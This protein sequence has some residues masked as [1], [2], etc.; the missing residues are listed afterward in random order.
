VIA[1]YCVPL[2]EVGG[3]AIAMKGR[4]E[5]TELE[6]GGRA[7]RELGAKIARVEPV[8]MIPEVGEKVRK[9][10]ILEKARKTPAQYPRK[11]GTAARRPLGAG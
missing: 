8:Q 6:E 1:E 4:L 10:V 5:R 3:Q 9:L 2:L 7:V 11:P